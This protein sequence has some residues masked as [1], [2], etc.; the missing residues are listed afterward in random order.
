[1][2]RKWDILKGLT[3][4]FVGNVVDLHALLTI[5]IRIWQLFPF[6]RVLLLLEKTNFFHSIF[7]LLENR[8]HSNQFDMTMD[9]IF[10]LKID[11]LFIEFPYSFQSYKLYS[12]VVS[13]S[14]TDTLIIRIN[15]NAFMSIPAVNISSINNI[16]LPDNIDDCAESPL[17]RWIQPNPTLTNWVCLRSRKVNHCITYA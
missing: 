15:S 4:G 17:L 14:W 5:V 6:Q 1:M 16:N 2:S 10:T 12:S 7:S 11:F 9:F 8:Q 13:P 3:L